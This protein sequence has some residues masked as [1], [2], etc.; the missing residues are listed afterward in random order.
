[1]P[2]QAKLQDVDIARPF[3]A[4]VAGVAAALISFSVVSVRGDLG[5]VFR[6]L[7]ARRVAKDLL[8]AGADPEKILAAKAHA[9]AVAREFA[10]P[11]AALSLWFLHLVIGALVAYGVWQLFAQ[12]VSQVG[13]RQD[14]QVRM[15]LRF[16]HR[17]G[18]FFLLRDLCEKSPLSTDQAHAVTTQ[19]VA[20][21]Q[22]VPHG[23]GYRLPS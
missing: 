19:M 8:A 7:R 2:I 10:N 20:D 14:I 3:L 21:G 16:A 4:S 18:G 13:L 6:F 5:G 1:M 12:R 22:L 11:E 23:E 9:L 15:V 17:H